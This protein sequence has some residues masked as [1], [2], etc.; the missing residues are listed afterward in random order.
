MKDVVNLIKYFLVGGGM[1][2]LLI[3]VTSSFAKFLITR[4]IISIGIA[5]IG[6]ILIVSRLMF[7]IYKK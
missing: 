7:E 6:L 4:P 5:F 1:L 2:A 3:F